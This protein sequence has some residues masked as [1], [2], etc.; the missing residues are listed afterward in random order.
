MSREDRLER[1][2]ERIQDEICYCYNCQ[3]YDSGE[4]IWVQGVQGDIEDLLDD[5][6]VPERYRDDLV[7]M[8]EC[9]NCGT[10]M[11]RHADIGLKEPEQIER[12]RKISQWRSRYAKKLV[13][14]YKHISKYPYLA[15]LHPL[16]RRIVR[17]I[18]LFPKASIGKETWYRARRVRSGKK[19]TSKQFLAPDTRKVRIPEGRYNHY[20]Q[21]H[22]YLSEDQE[23]AARETLSKGEKVVWI[24]KYEI[25][26][27]QSILDTVRW[28]QDEA[29]GIPVVPLGLLYSG[30]LK[31]KP[32]GD[33]NWK[34]EYFIPRFI[35]DC[36][37]RKGYS[38]ILYQG[39]K[40]TG[41]NLVL[42][43]PDKKTSRPIGKPS[44]YQL[45][46]KAPIIH[47]P[48]FVEFDLDID[49]YG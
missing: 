1:Y 37:K 14:F 20:A 25:K 36:A 18:D 34:P 15:A 39:A 12:E 2:V 21:S 27:V 40:S 42:F 24:H 23:G 26:G 29:I 30:V 8:L 6:R 35:A 22:L 49:D 33:S 4:M 48:D 17:E 28:W 44:L 11:S 32:Q 10:T 3:P 13:D 38:G 46:D 31:R 47:L 5:F 41:R 16:G 43:Y 9:H 7:T 45:K 19:L